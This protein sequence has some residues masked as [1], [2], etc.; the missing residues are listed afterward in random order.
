M[1]KKYYEVLNMSHLNFEVTKCKKH[2]SIQNN[3]KS[4]FI[5]L[6]VNLAARTVI[7]IDNKYFLAN[8][9]NYSAR[10][11]EKEE[12]ECVINILRKSELTEELKK[13]YQ[14][15][16][17]D[18]GYGAFF[19][20]SDT[21]YGYIPAEAI[22]GIYLN[23]D[24]FEEISKNITNK[25]NIKDL[26][27]EAKGLEYEFVYDTDKLIWKRNDDNKHL[28][29]TKFNLSFYHKNE[30]DLD[31]ELLNEK[32]EIAKREKLELGKKLEFIKTATAII[33]AAAVVQIF[34]FFN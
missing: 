9:K 5:A 29:I 21:D 32:D 10:A 7:E 24:I 28:S 15:K 13:N 25:L 34:K 26:A 14:F 33:A 8:E 17:D 11:K 6:E 18:I 12:A 4:E 2:Y 20:A 30:A 27:I 3:Y 16:N 19:S 22:F 1:V 23:D 31:E